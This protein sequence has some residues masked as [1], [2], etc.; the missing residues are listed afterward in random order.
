[1]KDKEWAY[2]AGIIDADGCISIASR[3]QCCRSKGTH[4]NAM[5]DICGDSKL[6]HWIK[7]RIKVR[8]AIKYK[9]YWRC[10]FERRDQVR[11]ILTNV[12]PYLVTKK[13]EAEIVLKL[14]NIPRNKVCPDI[15]EKMYQKQKA[16]KKKRK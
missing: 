11:H 16:I 2:L 1:M 8:I 5:I 4:Y 6:A 14:V 13:E 3:K 9:R 15:R 7:K 10:Y 12:I